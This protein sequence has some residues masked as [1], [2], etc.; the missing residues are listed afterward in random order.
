M[1]EEQDV[2][3]VS[4]DQETNEETSEQ[5]RTV[6]LEALEAERKKRQDIERQREEDRRTYQELL[7]RIEV[8][9]QSNQQPD[10]DEE[11]LVSRKDLKA[12]KQSL[13]SE[14]LFNLKR[15]IA[16]ETFKEMNPQAIK[17]INTSLK[18]IIEQK[19]WLAD[20]IANATNRY[21][22]AYEIVRD[23][24]GGKTSKPQT[25]NDAKKMVENS[26]KP[27]NPAATAKS[28]QL[29]GT[30]YLKSIAGTKEFREYRNK[31][32]GR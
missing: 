14:D 7:K 1:S 5:P 31:L 27:G 25:N 6:P 12:F 29:S 9:E 15:E 30:D 20:S 2:D 16:E 32:L 23:F 4:E 11:E 18:E 17:E 28:S 19:P 21:A 8:Q 3:P 10:E 26:K 24:G 13:T 22:R